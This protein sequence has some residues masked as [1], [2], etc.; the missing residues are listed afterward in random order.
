[1]K[2][3]VVPELSGMVDNVSD[4]SYATCVGLAIMALE[5]NFATSP[6]PSLSVSLPGGLKDAYSKAKGLF[7]NLLP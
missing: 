3:E 5:K 4:A 7:K 6:R 1:M 2:G